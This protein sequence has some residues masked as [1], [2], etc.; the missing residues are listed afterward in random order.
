MEGFAAASD[1][2]V[3]V[4][5]DTNLTPELIDEGRA[6]ELVHRIQ[7]MRKDAGFQVEDRIVTSYDATSDLASVMSTYDQYIRQ[8][9]LSVQLEAN[10]ASDG[11]TWS[12]A[13][14]GVD[15]S[16]AVRRS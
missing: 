15:I 9:T 5:L 14:D 2:G 3:T 1:G 6:R 12:G 10:G 16:L 11:H 8:E 13:I 7:T 4:A